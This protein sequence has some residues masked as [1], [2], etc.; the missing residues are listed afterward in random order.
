MELN[1]DSNGIQGFVEYNIELFKP[2]TIERLIDNFSTLL[3][4]I[5][6]NPDQNIAE[7]T[8]LN[9]DEK[10]FLLQDVNKTDKSYPKDQ[11]VHHLIE[12]QVLRSPDK[13]AVKYHEYQLTYDALNKRA[14]RLANFLI[15]NGAGPDKPVG[16]FMD[17]GIDM[18]V[19][20]LG[21]LK[22][23]SAYLPMDPMFPKDR[24][25]YMIEDTQ[26]DLL[27]TQD[28]LQNSFPN[29][30]GKEISIDNDWEKISSYP[31][32]CPGIMWD[33]NNLSYIIYTSGSTGKPKGVQIEHTSVVNFLLSM[34]K[35]PGIL[36]S[37]ILLSV[38]TL[39]FDI[40][41]LEIFLPLISGA[42]LLIIS[43]EESM[44]GAYL[45]NEIQNSGITI[46]QATPSTWRLML[47]AGWNKKLNLK[48][49]CGGEAIPKDLA[50]KLRDLGKSFWNVYGPTETTIWSTVKRIS[51][52]D[53]SI[54]IGTPLDNTKV[55]VLDKR[56]QV[57]PIG[58]IGELH[59][60]GAG[61]ARGYLNRPELTEERFIEDQFGDI[62]SEKLYK[63][64]DLA[65]ILSNGEIECLGRIDHQIKIRGFRIE[66]GEI[67]TILK[68]N[69][70]IHDAVVAI[71]DI[72]KK[73]P[74]LVAYL[75]FEDG[76]SFDQEQIIRLLKSKL[77]GYM[78]PIAFVELDSF[79][80][81]PNGK[82]D[83]KLLPDPIGINKE[84]NGKKETA[85][86]EVEKLLTKLWEELLD[87]TQIG[88]Y[89]DFFDLGGHSLI[90][91]KLFRQ[92]EIQ[93]G[94]SIPLATLFENPTIAY[95]AEIIHDEKSVKWS[96]LV[97]IQT[98]GPKTPLFL[99]HGAEGNVL[100]YRELAE[101][102]RELGQ[103]VYG[104]QSLGLDGKSEPSSS[105][106]E[107]AKTY[108][109]EILNNF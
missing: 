11:C 55:Y 52:Q 61:V 73:S 34:Q 83:R 8:I 16:I 41:V 75:I 43:K 89:D 79:P 78:I 84:D 109:D 60:A 101:R 90:A 49:L 46:M 80:L 96:S 35:R 1:R 67:E 21:I 17:R 42:T 58:V 26:T 22:S 14:N 44:D 2:D 68:S 27:I 38:T 105:I 72:N 65:R 93:F 15:N 4:S 104:L 19:A 50:F 98:E 86:D 45:L 77:P 91:A 82:I 32:N 6:A 18:V 107:M 53:E 9:S 92:I 70:I 59:I 94:K 51:K 88:I 33:S 24:L 69:S 7:I 81:T 85:R 62:E 40:S 106:N 48:V 5:V 99:V 57:V 39:S 87:V 25:E 76:S 100:L 47:D 10:H 37:D 23:G 64:G 66:L 30:Q 108:V 97:N 54:S 13:I 74:K 31:D 63:T 12:D 56:N 102:L 95:L 20:L 103:P 36:E 28:G 3:H 71:K 29:Y